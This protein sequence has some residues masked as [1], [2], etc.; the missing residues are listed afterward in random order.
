MYKNVLLPTDGSAASNAALEEALKFASHCGAAVRLVY[1]CEDPPYVL[2]EGPVDLGDA[3]ERQG[4]LIL[5]Q[6]AEKARKAAVAATTVLVKPGDR[7]VAAAITEEAERS[8]C[9]LIVMGTH[10]RRGLEHFLLG[11]VA[12]G[13]L[14]RSKVPVLLLRSR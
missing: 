9:D 8:G 3:I 1:V 4:E 11:S 14:R 10:G 5:A 13:V 7:R 2:A 6:A 12:E